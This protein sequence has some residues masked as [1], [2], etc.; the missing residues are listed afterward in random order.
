[1]MGCRVKPGNDETELEPQ[2][3]PQQQIVQTL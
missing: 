1:M 3:L 2:S